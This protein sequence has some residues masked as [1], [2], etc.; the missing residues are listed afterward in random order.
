MEPADQEPT[1]LEL[2]GPDLEVD[3]CRAERWRLSSDAPFL[4]YADLLLLLS[5][6]RTIRRMGNQRK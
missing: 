1:A 2:T 5:L 6:R 3:V 4:G